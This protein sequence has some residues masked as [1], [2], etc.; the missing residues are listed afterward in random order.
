MAGRRPV[1]PASATAA[2]VT[3]RRRTAAD[4]H[5]PPARLG[6]RPILVTGFGPFPG[7]AD[8][9]SAALAAALAACRRHRPALV[10]IVLAT[11]WQALAALEG[12]MR[13]TAP[14]AV[15]HIGVAPR[16]ALPRLETRA[17]N[18]AARLPDAADAR[19]QERRLDAAGPTIRRA[20]AV[21]LSA[22]TNGDLRRSLDPGAYLCN[23]TLYRSLA[24]SPPWRPLA[25]LH[26][27]PVALRRG[28]RLGDLRLLA[29]AIVAGL[30]RSRH[31][32]RPRAQSKSAPR[33]T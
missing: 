15:L 1:P 21:P 20:A 4:G 29:E 18:H 6:G 26:I 10:A 13:D 3:D 17:Y 5:A 24:L 22:A 2:P 7:V 16:A 31:P 23:A 14:L 25:F 19:P 11:E 8:N 32:P 28:A 12:L 33:A 9:P 27:P 30:L